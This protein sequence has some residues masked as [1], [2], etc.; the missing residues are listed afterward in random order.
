MPKKLAILVVHGM[1]TQ[2]DEHFADDMIDEVNQKVKDIGS[3]PNDIAW[4]P[5]FWASVTQPHENKLWDALS[6]GG[7]LDCTKIRKFVINNLGD[8]VA[9][10]REPGSSSDVYQQIHAVIHGHLVELRHIAGDKDVPLIVMGHSLGSYIMSNYIWDQNQN[11]QAA[12]SGTTPFERMETLAGFI[13]FGS[14]IALFS[15]A[16]PTYE[17]IRFPPDTL[18]E[19]LRSAA[20]WNNYYDPE[21]VLGYPI[22][23]LCPDYQNNPQIEDHLIEV[24]NIFT[25]WNLLSHEG[26]WTDDDFTEPVGDQI[27]H[28]LRLL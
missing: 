4:R 24:G 6:K 23:P 13:T 9:Y 14:N 16:L 3:D 11:T 12:I 21:D 10:Q 15:L 20:Q 17:G 19:P 2:K 22:K 18:A 26:Y 27:A 25:S 8:A 7:N 5:G 28:L 1:G